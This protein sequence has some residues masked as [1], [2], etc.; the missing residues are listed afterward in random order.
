[1][2][3][4][5]NHRKRLTKI[6]KRHGVEV[7]H[8]SNWYQLADRLTDHFGLAGRADRSAKRFCYEVAECL[9]WIPRRAPEQNEARS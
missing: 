3:R 1:M 2:K 6:A 5:T 9:G 4:T 8:V 7:A